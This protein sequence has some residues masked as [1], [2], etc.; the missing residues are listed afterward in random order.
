LRHLAVLAQGCGL[1]AECVDAGGL[2]PVLAALVQA[3]DG[4]VLDVAS[5]AARLAPDQ[6]ELLATQ[7]ENRSLPVLLLASAAAPA[8][9][10]LTR[11]TGGGVRGVEP[12]PA[13]GP[14]G[15]PA[16]ASLLAS[17]LAGQT[18]PRA[19]GGAL[20]LVLG[21]AAGV[22]VLMT[23]GGAPALVKTR[24]GKAD[25]FVW[26]ADKVFDMRRLLPVEREFEEAADQYVPAII[27]LRLA[28]GG[29]CWQNPEPLAGLVID[30]PLLKNHYGFINFSQLLASARRH[31]YH[32]TLAFIPWNYWRGRAAQARMFL[33][34]ADCFSVCVHGCDHTRRE[35]GSADYADLLARNFTAARRM[36]RL[37]TRTG[38]ASE[39]VMVCPQELY[40]LE[41]MR[42]FADSRQFLA[43]TCSA[44]LPRD[45]PAPALCGADLLLPAQDSFYGVPVFKRHYAGSLAAFAM[46]LF[47]G[48]PAILVEHHEFFR[49]GPGGVEAFAAQLAQLRPGIQ[50]ASVAEIARRTHWR[51]RLADGRQEVR[52][53]TDDFKLAH[54]DQTVA[55]YRLVRR[56]PAAPPVSGVRVDGA[57]VPFAHAD[58]W[59]SFE[60]P[61]REPRTF[62]I[63]LEIP[64]VQPARARARGPAYHVAVALRRGLSEFR[65][66][67]IARNDFL[68]RS[69]KALARILKQTS[70]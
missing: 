1:A 43:L 64:A 32:V 22:E 18:Y 67:V 9:A 63:K 29:R 60:V 13:G 19:G 11:L 6:L 8:S 52:F 45:L 41:A 12:H 30:D 28:G 10:F 37:R 54:R 44:C 53:F 5:L 14:V 20:K 2:D 23:L 66:N 27:F 49:P 24:A 47:L 40:S 57:N 21:P 4:V 15:F 3:Q 36:A 35:F 25:V 68:L 69:A 65:D 39:P 46:A 38:V 17:E 59:L 42:A 55:G 48:K 50:W 33:D 56:L 7:I 26:C 34:Y 58:G 61:A 70:L 51:R 16:N 31:Q 62:E